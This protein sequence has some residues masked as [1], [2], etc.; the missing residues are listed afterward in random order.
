[1]LAFSWSILMTLNILFSNFWGIVL[2]EWK[3]V[4]KKTRIILIA[5]LA[6]LVFSLIFPELYKS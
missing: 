6:V 5:G 1:M 3:G 4:S 2:K